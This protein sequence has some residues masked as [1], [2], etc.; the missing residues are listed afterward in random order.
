MKILK[1]ISAKNVIFVSLTVHTFHKQ[2]VYKQLV[3]GLQIA[4]QQEGSTLFHLA[5][6]KTADYRKKEFF[7]CNKHKIAV[8]PTIHRN[9]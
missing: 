3:L 5:T 9:S 7:F 8:K 4:K 6:I 1:S 2:P